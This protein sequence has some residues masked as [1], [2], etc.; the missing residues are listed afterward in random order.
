MSD[1]QR[2][3]ARLARL[4]QQ[5]QARERIPALQVAIH[6][7][8]RPLWTCEVGT[9]GRAEAP[10][11]PDSRLRMG[12][13][14]KTFTATL[15][16][17]CRD[18]GLLDLDDPVSRFLEVPAHGELTIRRL[19][20]H[21]SGLQREPYGDVWDT[22]RMPDAARV[23]AELDRV[24]RVLPTARRYHYSNLGMAILGQVVA[25]L[26]GASWAEVLHDRILRPLHLTGIDQVPGE[27]GVVGYLVDA[28]SDHVRAEPETELA[29][30][31]PAGQLWATA[32]DLARWAAFLAD[33]STVD[34]SARVLAP[35]TVEEMRWPLTVTDEANWAS[36]FGLGLILVPR[37]DRVTHVGHDGAMPG[38][39]A[40]A[41]GRYGGTDTPAA[42]GVAALGS[43]GTALAIGELVH[44]LLAVDAA[45]FPP[46]ITPWR[47]GEPA[48]ADLRPIL[49][50]WW[51]EGFEYVFTWR[52]G[53][54]H[55]RRVLDAA[56]KPPSVFERLPGSDDLRTRS[57]GEAGERLRLV[58]D[59]A[60]GV[61]TELRWATY[62]FTRGQEAFD[63]GS[64]SEP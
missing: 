5:V 44:T 54:L 40:S 4:V 10:L 17:Q 36:G 43:S 28:W 21:T 26:R 63:G 19:L 35:S 37:P 29:G 24:E 30:V 57:G 31:A 45:E 55:A 52:E 50:R 8:D 16:M 15:V 7:A 49:G 53:A 39:I 22:L 64:P 3:A 9:S 46:P 25:R 61:V 13:I 60:T 14:T 27:R 2:R 47:P 58:R 62:R 18:E 42:F 32:T 11:G 23:L 1:E 56:H 20:S 6:R 59:P 34:P 33:P 12:S 41:Y 51:S 48:P 38:F